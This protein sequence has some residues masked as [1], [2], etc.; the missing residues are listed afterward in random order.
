MR[1]KAESAKAG[2]SS[3]CGKRDVPQL[4]EQAKQAISSLKVGPSHGYTQA[5]LDFARECGLSVSQLDPAA[6]EIEGAALAFNYVKGG[7]MVRPE[8]HPEEIP[9]RLRALN[10]WYLK[11]AK[12]GQE[13]TCFAPGKD[14]FLGQDYSLSIT[15]EELFR[16]FNLSDIDISIV[17]CYT[18]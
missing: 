3:A 5:E 13:M 4:G 10:K 14:H 11:V 15:M 2:S 8:L 9:T 16:F 12:Q 1:R 17:S 18:L 7:P 6:K